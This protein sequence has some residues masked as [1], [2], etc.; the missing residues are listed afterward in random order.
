MPNYQCSRER[1]D[2]RS[3]RREYTILLQSEC[4]HQSTEDILL[5][6]II[7]QQKLGQAMIEALEPGYATA[8][9]TLNAHG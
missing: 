3:R 1:V 9:L 4:L 7:Y 8:R 5:T 2:G 6:K